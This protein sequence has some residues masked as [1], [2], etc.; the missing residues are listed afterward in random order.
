M[1]G[2]K[3]WGGDGPGEHLRHGAVVG[4]T[5]FVGLGVLQ[6]RR[7]GALFGKGDVVRAPLLEQTYLFLLLRLLFLPQGLKLDEVRLT[8]HAGH[9]G[10]HRGGDGFTRLLVVPSIAV[11][12]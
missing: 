8:G 4:G 11:A 7:L 5:V 3:L 2:K 10:E 12:P 6:D 9:L 1:P